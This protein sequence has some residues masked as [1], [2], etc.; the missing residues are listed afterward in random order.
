MN[1]FTNI[2]LAIVPQDHASM[3]DKMGFLW[4]FVIGVC[5]VAFVL[6]QIVLIYFVVKYRRKKGEP[7]KKTPFITHSTK[8]E[9]IWTVVPGIIMMVMFFFGMKYFLEMRTMPKDALTIDVV[10]KQWSWDFSYKMVTPAKFV[11]TVNKCQANDSILIADYVTASDCNNAKLE[12]KSNPKKAN[13]LACL[14]ENNNA[15]TDITTKK[16]CEAAKLKW[17]YGEPLRVPVNT[18]IVMRMTSNDVI[19]SF[20]LPA[21]GFGVKQDVLPK[22]YSYL[23]FEHNKVGTYD[24][25]CAEYCGKDHSGMVGKVVVMPQADFQ[26]WLK[27]G[28]TAN[29]KKGPMSTKELIAFGK[30]V[31]NGKGTCFACHSTQGQVGAG[32]AVDKLYGKM[33]SLTTGKKV[34]VDENYLIES[35]VEPKAKIVK[36]FGAI[37]SVQNVNDQEVKALVEYIKSLK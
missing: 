13:G 3:A 10:G 7:N 33:E 24:I 25:Y 12:W 16:N 20:F 9:T 30:K 4:N 22:Q 19:H 37:M 27:G 6:L 36:G 31:F 5:I 17:S 14:T 26:T 35:I 21:F 18:K 8:L 11:N 28:S 34:K 29:K 1:L 23:W 32:P 2:I 15:I